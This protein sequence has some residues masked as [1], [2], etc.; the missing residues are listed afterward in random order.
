LDQ[1]DRHLRPHPD[2]DGLGVKDT[3]HA[4][5]VRQHAADEAVDEI[6][7]GDVDQDATSAT[8]NQLLREVILQGKRELVVHVDL[9]ADQQASADLE[10]GDV[11]HRATPASPKADRPAARCV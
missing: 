10:D 7:G 5:N 4:G 8:G 2:D 11:L 3:S 6:E 1:G 9:N